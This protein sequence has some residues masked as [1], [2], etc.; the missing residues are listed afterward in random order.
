[1]DTTPLPGDS[2]GAHLQSEAEQRG[3]LA[4]EA[5]AGNPGGAARRRRRTLAALADVDAHLIDDEAMQAWAESLG[6]D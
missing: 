6:T 4:D 3:R 2:A 1:M 5:D